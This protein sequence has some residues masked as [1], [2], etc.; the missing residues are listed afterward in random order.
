MSVSAQKVVVVGQGYV[1]LPLAVRVVEAGHSVVGLDVDEMRVKRLAAGESFA[2]D[3]SSPRLMA[4]LN[5]GRY[6]LSTD[7]ADAA[8]FD[9]CVITV[10]TPLKDGAP[11]LSFVE[12][13]AQSVAP[14]L[15]A[16]ATVILES[17]TYPCTTEHVVCPILEAHSGLRAGKDFFLGYSPERIDPGNPTWQLENTPKVVSGIDDLSLQHVEKFYSDVVERTVPVS[18][19][20]T[21]ELTKLLENTFRHVNI[22]LVNEL[23][24]F[25]R[26]LG[27]D[28]WEVIDAASTKPF[29]YMRFLPGPGVG[30]HCLPIDPSYLSWQV[31]QALQHDFRFVALAN[32]INSHMPDHVVL[33]VARG[34]NTRRKPVNGSR[35]MVLGLA[36]KRNTGDIRE[37]PSVAVAQGLQKLGAH[38]VAVEPY[39]DAS[40]LPQDILCVQ[41][42]EEQVAAADAVVVATDHD[43]FDYAMVERVADYVF[44]ACNRCRSEVAERL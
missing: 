44:D 6:L 29:G 27:I 31:K 42:T 26:P 38:V 4:A 24:M 3:V 1:G 10:P 40:H 11:D 28:I 22:A 18:S 19:P 12:S 5:S 15:K 43:I 32:D 41:L 8:G 21:A 36:Y 17:T 2:E 16:N 20:R 30:G 35:I 25:C 23:A 39:V 13:A 34:L 37:S 33:R 14:H 7:Y 9:V